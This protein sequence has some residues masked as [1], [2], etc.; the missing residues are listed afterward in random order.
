MSA[1]A[2]Q[3]AVQTKFRASNLSLTKQM[4]SDV[5]YHIAVALTSISF[6]HLSYT[7]TN[8]HVFLAENQVSEL[9]SN[10]IYMVPMTS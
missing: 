6:W 10:L 4:R 5:C 3:R 9:Q 8:F 1:E 7:I 2:S